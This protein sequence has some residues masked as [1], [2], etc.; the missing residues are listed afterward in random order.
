[1]QN[2]KTTLIIIFL[3]CITGGCATTSR[4]KTDARILKQLEDV[5]TVS[6]ALFTCSDPIIAHTVRNMIIEALLT[7]YSI[8]IGGEADVEIK[9]TISLSPGQISSEGSLATASPESSGGHVS[10]INAQI[11]K[12]RKILAYLTVSQSR[13]ISEVPDSPEVMG[14]KTGARIKEI[15]SR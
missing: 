13:A 14:R 5:K 11:V 1:M 3:A 2:I 7:D 12:N 10:R 15:F 9:G 8:V 4:E 6:V